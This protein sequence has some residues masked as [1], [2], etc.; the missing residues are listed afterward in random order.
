MR[1]SD[2]SKPVHGYGLYL[3]DNGDSDVCGFLDG[4]PVLVPTNVEKDGD[5]RRFRFAEGTRKLRNLG[6]VF[7]PD[8]EAAAFV[9]EAI[10]EKLA[11][12]RDAANAFRVTGASVSRRSR[13]LFLRVFV[14]GIES[15]EPD[16]FEFTLE[17]PS[18]EVQKDGQRVFGQ[19]LEAIGLSGV[20]DSDELVGLTATFERRHGQRMF[21]RWVA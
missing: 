2:T 12:D 4:S 3:Y 16:C 6:D 7:C 14:A 18:Y 10:N 9:R 11:R 13:F 17:A 15:G 1:I 8:I 21:K 5:R 19:F 20:E